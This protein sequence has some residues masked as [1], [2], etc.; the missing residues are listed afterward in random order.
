MRNALM[1][2]WIQDVDDL[3]RNFSPANKYWEE[4]R[5]FTPAVDVTETEKEF[6]FFF[7]L[8][9]MSEKD[10]S[11]TVVGRELQVTGERKLAEKDE[12]QK[13]HRNERFFGRF[14]RTFLLPEEVE[15]NKIDAQFKDG[16]LEIR[17][18][19]LEAAQPKTIPI[20][21]H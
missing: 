9:G 1:T 11:L 14:D 4:K 19:K 7:D 15:S 21:T 2:N 6:L 10:L 16:V 3:F 13:H 8:P 5:E 20:R 12:A 17:V 18:P